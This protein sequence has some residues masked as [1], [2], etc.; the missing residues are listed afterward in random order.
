L[1][2]ASGVTDAVVRE[3]VGHDSAAVS[4]VYTHIDSA[5]LGYPLELF[6]M[7][8]SG[9]LYSHAEARYAN[10]DSVRVLYPGLLGGS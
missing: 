6:E 1:L 7:K 4:R 10:Y 2:K 3:I 9:L 5:V 8:K